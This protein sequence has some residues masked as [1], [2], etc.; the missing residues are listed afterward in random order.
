MTKIKYLVIMIATVL[1]VTGCSSSSISLTEDEINAIAQYSAY[2]I[3]KHEDNHIVKEKLLDKRDLEE[4]REAAETEQEKEEDSVLETVEDIVPTPTPTTTPTPVP[5]EAPVE[6]TEDPTDTAK[7]TTPVNEIV[8][9]SEK[10][11]KQI[12]KAIS[13]CYNEDSFEI[14]YR[15]YE[16][17][18]TYKS[19]YEYFS[20]TAPTGVK[21]L[22]LNFDIKNVSNSEKQFDFFDHQ[23]DFSL[24]ADTTT[25]IEPRISLLANDLQFLNRKISAGETADA[26]LLFYIDRIYESIE[27]QVTSTDV[28]DGNNEK[29]YKIKIN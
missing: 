18:D 11:T 19:V 2:L 3:L 6:T 5:T 12:A 7:A 25:I 17:C 27:L 29:I 13:E 24:A 9:A 15:N 28:S 1:L 4:A 8:E 22:I 21:L 10:A 26:V 14:T 16:V 20:V 23:V